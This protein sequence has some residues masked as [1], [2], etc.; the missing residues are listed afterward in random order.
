MTRVALA[1]LAVLALA[2]APRSGADFTASASSPGNH[3]TAAADFNTVAVTLADPSAAV[4]G[5]VGLTATA[6]S[7]RGIAT[8]RIDAAVAGSGTWSAVCTA[9][10]APYQCSWDTTGVA[11]GRYDLRAV[12]TDAAGYTRTAPV[13]SRTV[14]NQ[15]PA[16]TLNNPGLY[17]GGTV[18]LG[19]TAS[20]PGSGVLNVKVQ[21]RAQGA[22]TWND[23]C[24]DATAPYS[25]SLNTTT[26]TDGMYELQA[27]AADR[28]GRTTATAP[29][30]TRVDNTA[31]TATGSV[32]AT[33]RGTVTVSATASDSESGIASVS[34][35]ALYGGVWYP[36]CV[37]T[38]AP[39]S[40][41][42]DSHSVADGSYSLRLVTTNG[43]GVK[44]T[45]ATFPIQVDNTAPAGADVQA[46][47]G[48]GVPGQLDSGDWLTLTYSEP[49]APG[50]VLSGWTGAAQAV[51]VK[52]S[53]TDQ[54]DVYDAAGTTRLNL[55]STGLDLNLG[56]DFVTAAADFDATLTQS[57]N[58]ITVTL[59]ALR[60]GTLAASPAG[61]GTLTWKPSASATDLAGNAGT[62]TLV[63]ESGAGDADF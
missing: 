42:A 21:Q 8:V 35:E 16:V 31:P 59:G 36:V 39:Y 17:V 19:A 14:D 25:C 10:S 9:A 57:G 54:L 61:V 58:S 15:P 44:T 37:D 49:I 48:G 60:T 30:T 62:T 1:A 6:S 29:V 5:T 22:T 46:G 28:V 43:A 23:V 56:A 3:F 55:V 24:T 63:T 18:A 7:G 53:A 47:N 20:D 38:A 50:S 41:S 52:V 40:C 51:R 11:D 4:Q 33:G 26:L 13:A 2:A 32:P 34:F 27:V 12:A 45:S